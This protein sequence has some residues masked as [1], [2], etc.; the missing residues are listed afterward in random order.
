MDKDSLKYKILLTL[1]VLAI[2]VAFF[3]IVPKFYD[4]NHAKYT[5][6]LLEDGTV[7]I[8]GYT[9]APS[10]LEVPKE[11]DG[12]TVSAISNS[13]FAN[14]RE[15]KEVTLPESVGSI[16]EYAFY[17][18]TGLRSIEAPGTV[19]IGN[20]A[21]FGCSDLRSVDWSSE[22]R[23]IGASAFASCLKLKSLK[24]PASCE[25]IGV[26]AFMACE[27]LV[28]DC[29]ENDMAAQVAAQYSI[30]TD[31]A[32][33]DDW[34]LLQVGLIVLAVVAVLAAVMLIGRRRRKSK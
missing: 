10:K 1:S 21:F 14:K 6:T 31:F 34:I 26:D 4:N 19:R 5:Y 15:L 13:A 28:L 2:T 29:S 24:V 32:D 12:Y 7:T 27:S 22:L 25:E 16:G 23:S 3:L 9:G 33:S 11:I 18:C 30:P 8:D 17:D 20:Y